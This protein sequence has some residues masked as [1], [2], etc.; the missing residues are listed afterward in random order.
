MKVAIV[1]AGAAGCFAAIEIKR[2]RPDAEV[3][4]ME[5]GKKALAK[6]AITGGGRCNLTNSFAQVRSLEQ[7]YPRGH[8]LLK[9]LFYHFSNEDTCNWFERE[10]VRLV[11]QEDECVFPQ[12]QD[13]MEI[14]NTLLRLMRQLGVKLLLETKVERVKDLLA[15]YD[16]VLVTV[17]GQTT[18]AHSCL[19]DGIDVD[20]VPSLPSLF[21]MVI[22]DDSL[23]SLMGTVVEEAQLSLAGTKMKSQGALLLT[24]WGISGPATLKLSSLAARVLAESEYKSQVSINWLGEYSHAEV[25]ELLQ[26]NIKECAAKKLSS[27]YPEQ[28]NSRLWIHLLKRAG[29]SA[30]IRWKELQGR[31]LNQLHNTLTNDIYKVEGKNRFKDE[32]VISG[33]VSLSSLNPKTLEAKNQPGL[34]FAGEATDVDAIT[35]GFNLQAAWTMGIVAARSI[36]QG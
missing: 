1:G 21:S 36:S 9:K 18:N 13:A 23:R 30:E 35:G 8:R 6:V 32:F 34:Y 28:L 27:V 14:V 33:G 26:S 31:L 19:L 20:I 17:G 24:H 15:E 10:G 4:V 29:L 3:V 7:V 25:M 22:T 16:K 11:T 5:K 12:S 2:Q